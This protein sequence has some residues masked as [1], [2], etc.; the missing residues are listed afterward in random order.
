VKRHIIFSGKPLLCLFQHLLGNIEKGYGRSGKNIKN[1]GGNQT[2]ACA[3]VQ[4]S[5]FFIAVKR[6]QPDQGLVEIVKTGNHLSPVPVILKGPGIEYLFYGHE[7][8][9]LSISA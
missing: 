3:Q 9:F 4:D 8:P 6:Y 2:R 5:K 1:E 7:N